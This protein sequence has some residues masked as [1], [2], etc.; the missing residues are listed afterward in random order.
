MLSTGEQ[1]FT[2]ETKLKMVEVRN[3]RTTVKSLR[4]A[5]APASTPLEL[6]C[7]AHRR[8]AQG[9][10]AARRPTSDAGRPPMRAV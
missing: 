4:I 8:S 6:A 7:P 3:A 9:P 2:I 1:Q 5:R 10:R